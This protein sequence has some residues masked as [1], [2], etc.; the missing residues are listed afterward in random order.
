MTSITKLDK[1]DVQLLTDKIIACLS[2]QNK[3]QRTLLAEA[4]LKGVHE[5]LQLTSFEQYLESC[6]TKSK[7]GM[8]INYARKQANAGIV[9]I[10]ILGKENIGTMREYPLRILYENVDECH[11]VPVYQLARKGLKNNKYPTANQIID[12]AKELGF[13]RK[14]KSKSNPNK[15][16]EAKEESANAKTNEGKLSKKANIKPEINTTS[17]RSSAKDVA[18]HLSSDEASREIIATYEFDDIR[19]IMGILKSVQYKAI[20]DECDYIINHCK[21]NA[22]KNLIRKLSTHL[23]NSKKDNLFEKNMF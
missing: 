21:E 4:K 9:E 17:S 10:Q 2:G 22:I 12:S 16:L 6:I 20:V 8:E 5:T 23:K 7:I 3:E 14:K 15:N 19:R 1:E 11:R 18:K 13:Y